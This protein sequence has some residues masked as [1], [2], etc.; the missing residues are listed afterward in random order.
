MQVYATAF[1]QSCL[2]M[3]VAISVRNVQR[4]QNHNRENSQSA[5]RMNGNRSSLISLVF[6]H[7]NSAFAFSAL[8]RHL[9]KQ[10]LQ[11]ININKK[12]HS[13][14]VT[15]HKYLKNSSFREVNLSAGNRDSYNERTD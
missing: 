1:F 6:Y 10:K 15:L 4:C 9:P 7:L 5:G 8:Y 14:P 13:S 3:T 12:Y 11:K 2:T